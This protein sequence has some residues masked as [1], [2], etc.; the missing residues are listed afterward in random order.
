ME[1]QDYIDGLVREK[2]RVLAYD[3]ERL[4][5]QIE[6]DYIEPGDSLPGIDTTVASNDNL[7]S[8]ALQTGDNSHTGACY[9]LPHWGVG[10]L[11]RDTDTDEMAKDLI[12]QVLDLIAG[13]N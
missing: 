4:K 7:S 5:S 6:D 9:G 1:M 13:N 10:R 3:L 2:V 8:W 11:Y 12:D